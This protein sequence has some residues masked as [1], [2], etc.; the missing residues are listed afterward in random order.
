MNDVKPNA[1]ASLI[2]EMKGLNRWSDMDIVKQA[3]ERRPD[4]RLTKQDI[5]GWRRHGMPTLNPPKLVALAAGLHLPAYR[6][7][8]VWLGEKGIDFPADGITPEDAIHQDHTL[9]DHTK[10]AV[11]HLIEQDR[12]SR[13]RPGRAAS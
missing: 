11:L 8:S 3:E 9:T 4:L 7:V 13:G 6:V 5:S 1:L 12:R 2:D 10:A